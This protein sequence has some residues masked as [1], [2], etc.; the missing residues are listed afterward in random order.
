MITTRE[1]MARAIADQLH[2][3]TENFPAPVWASQAVDRVLDAMR[4]PDVE[5]ALVGQKTRQEESGASVI[6]MDM[7]DAI[8]RGG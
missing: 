3:G 7:I 8:K 2:P 4:V 6:W 1:K 5:V